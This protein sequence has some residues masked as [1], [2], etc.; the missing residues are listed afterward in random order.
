MRRHTFISRCATRTVTLAFLVALAAPATAIA[1]P[2]PITPTQAYEAALEHGWSAKALHGLGTAYE[3]AG[4]HGPAILALE[5][6]RLLAPRDGDITAALESARTT[7]G[8]THPQHS[9]LHDTIATL[10]TDEWTWL[11]L[12]AGAL[13]CG[14]V[15]AFAWRRRPTTMR[16][17]ALGSAVVAVVA[18]TGA[19]I[20]APDPDRA[21]V[22][23]TATARLSPFPS[24]EGVFEALEG[25]TVQVERERSGFF[26]VRDG[27][28]GGWIPQ[29]AVTRVIPES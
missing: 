28:R 19:A 2:D 25:E 14:F 27:E 10:T 20:S 3:S 15:V 18:A 8:V 5:R 4:K 11:A 12:G 9:R 21:I 29:T 24:A 26:F 22:T 13:T 16:S 17:L 6:A 1:A 23:T 7:A